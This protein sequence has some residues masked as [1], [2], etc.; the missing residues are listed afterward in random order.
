MHKAVEMKDC[1]VRRKALCTFLFLHFEKF[2]LSV[3]FIYTKTGSG[4]FSAC[5]GFKVLHIFYNL[6]YCFFRKL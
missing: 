1:A 5:M 3:P 4:Y 6:M 2:H